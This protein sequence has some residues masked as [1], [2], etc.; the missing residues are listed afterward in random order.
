MPL[1]TLAT[2]TLLS[3]CVTAAH[4]L[5]TLL[6]EGHRISHRWCAT[7]VIA[8]WLLTVVFYVLAPVSGFRLPVVLPIWLLLASGVQ[9]TIGQRPGIKGVLAS[10]I[11]GALSQLHHS[12]GLVLSAVSL[13]VAAGLGLRVLK[14]LVDPPL[15]WDALTY[16]LVKA[17]RWVQHGGW[18]PDA[19]PDAWRYYEYFPPGGDVLWAWAMLPSHSDALIAPAGGLVWSVCLLAAYGVARALH[20]SKTAAFSTALAIV[21]MPCVLSF[22]TSAYV[23]G[24]LLAYLLLGLAFV[25]LA[26]ESGR[27]QDAMLAAAALGL[28]AGV[29]ALALPLLAIGLTLVVLTSWRRHGAPAAW[30][31]WTVCLVASAPLL[32]GYVIAWIG[33]GSPLYPLALSVGGK[34]I[35]AG[36]EQLAGVFSGAFVA[37]APYATTTFLS[38]L[39]Y[40]VHDLLIDHLN[41]GAGAIALVILGAVGL[42]SMLADRTRHMALLPLLSVIVIPVAGI[43]SDAMLSQ[44]TSF[45]FIAARLIAPSLAALALIGSIVPGRTADVMRA[46][47]I[48]GGIAYAMPRTI[49]EV[50]LAAISRL[51]PYVLGGVT[52]TV[53]AVGVG[54]R[55]RRTT[56]ALIVGTVAGLLLISAGVHSTRT[57][58]R[59]EIYRSTIGEPSRVPYDLVP[60][61]SFLV[62]WQIWADLDQGQPW[63]IAF[64]AG[65][66][67]FNGHTSF[68]YPLLGSRLQNTVLYV[69]PT[70]DGDVI[71]YQKRDQLLRELDL[72]VWVQRLI[73]ERIDVVVVA[74]PGVPEL[75]WMRR[76]PAVFEPFSKSPEGSWTWAFRVIVPEARRLVDASQ[77]PSP[78]TQR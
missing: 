73:D 23:T 50:E 72:R 15:A 55:I 71:D 53:L 62:A 21:A 59:Y 46:I 42:T 11:R 45:A 27:I 12:S 76:H 10:D 32:T 60:L 39:F 54:W 34:T 4:P 47:A 31:V 28:A 1:D 43:M 2:M 5:A 38:E 16:H 36:N 65:W 8:S 19:A 44:R 41:F 67:G 69:P 40:D 57:A 70:R 33:T 18:A 13:A 37:Q 51:V 9:M 14:G 49:S 74:V 6:T 66:D 17:G 25:L 7:A 58:F 77:P 29:Q 48:V 35:L 75:D 24:V 20:A 22:V 68:R 64:A 26:L 63:R 30:R 52:V 3:A 78:I 61:S 56:H